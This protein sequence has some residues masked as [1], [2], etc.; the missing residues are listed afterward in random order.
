MRKLLFSE[1]YSDKS[2]FGIRVL[3]RVEITRKLTLS[4][5]DSATNLHLN[6]ELF[7]G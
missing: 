6:R 1:E 2:N 3:Y 4:I 5:I 7:S